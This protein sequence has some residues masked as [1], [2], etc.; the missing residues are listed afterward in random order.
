MGSAHR[1]T[2]VDILSNFDENRFRGSGDMKRTWKALTLTWG[3]HDWVID[4]ARRLCERNIWLKFKEI[5]FRGS[6]V[7]FFFMFFCFSFFSFSFFFFLGGGGGGGGGGGYAGKV[8]DIMRMTKILNPGFFI[9]FFLFCKGRWGMG[10]A[11]GRDRGG[12]GRGV[13]RNYFHMWLAV[14]T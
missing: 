4:S 12:V 5:H 8:A 2:D 3:P 9:L 14:S 10:A 11:K 6:D 1:L 13:G 7:V